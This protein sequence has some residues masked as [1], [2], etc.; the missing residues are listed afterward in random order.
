LEFDKQN[1]ATCPESS[2]KYRLQENE[3]VK[4]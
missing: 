2:E 4:L 3:V 1:L